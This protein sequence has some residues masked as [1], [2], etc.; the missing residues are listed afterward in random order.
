MRPNVSV[1]FDD[2]SLI[3]EIWSVPNQIFTVKRI[4]KLIERKYHLVLSE[5]EKKMLGKRLSVCLLWMIDTQDAR[6]FSRTD[7]GA[8][9]YQKVV[10]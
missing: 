2:L 4:R 6:I 1:T 5:N 7:Y 10:N 9:I 3:R 8:I